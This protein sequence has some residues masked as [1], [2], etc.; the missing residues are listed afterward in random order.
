MRG[1]IIGAIIACIV[2]IG[3]AVLFTVNGHGSGPRLVAMDSSY[4]K[5]VSDGYWVKGAANPKV[6]LTEY[7]D[8]QCEPC[9]TGY[10]ISEAALR[11]TSD[12]VQFRVHLYPDATSYPNAVAAARTAEAAGRQGKFWPM[13]NIL[14]ANQS[15]WSGITPDSA[16]RLF[17][18]Y[19]KSL[20]VNIDQYRSDL[21]D[22]TIS[23]PIDRDMAAGNRIPL[24]GTPSFLVN[25]QLLSSFP[26]S[27]SDLVTILKAATPQT[28]TTLTP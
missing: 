20:A 23:D 15:Q 3:A 17:E 27:S 5:R 24:K 14:F 7:T 9:Q 19:A 12:F 1:V 21:A 11:Q 22:A 4:E 13:Y 16:K 25:D 28:T 18:S 8:F 2:L 10:S 26:Q 6:I